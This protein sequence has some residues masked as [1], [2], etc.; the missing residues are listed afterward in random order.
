MGRFLKHTSDLVLSAP[1]LVPFLMTI[2]ILYGVQSGNWLSQAKP[3]SSF[4][5]LE[6][7][8]SIPHKPGSTE[9]LLQEIQTLKT[10]TAA[11]LPAPRQSK[12]QEA[13]LMMQYFSP[14]EKP[15][16]DPFAPLEVPVDIMEMAK[17]LDDMK[18]AQVHVP[19]DSSRAI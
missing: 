9:A 18:P 4:A 8:A 15:R 16:R 6:M 7:D 1:F 14:S 2:L 13:S 12:V 19:G 5:Q 10:E 11:L 17:Q 3:V